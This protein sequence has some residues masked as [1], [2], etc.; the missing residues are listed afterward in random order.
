MSVKTCVYA[1]SLNEIKHIDRFLAA[2]AEADLILICDTGSTDGTVEHI[3]EMQRTKHNIVLHNIV[4][5]PW[6]FDVV[7]NTA[8]SLVPSD[9]DICLSIDIDEFL[10]PGWNAAIQTT[11]TKYP[12]V[13]RFAYDYIWSWN[14]DGTPA[15]RFNADKIHTRF[16]YRWKHPCHETLYWEGADREQRVIIDGLQLQHH[17]DNTKSRSQYLGLLK[18][19]V[20]EDANNDRMAHYYARELMFTGDHAAAITEFKR[21][22]VLPTATW[23]EE[24]SASMRY[25]A[26]CYEKLGDVEQAKIWGVKAA[27][28]CPTVREP[29]FELARISYDT[30]DWETCL[31]ASQKCLGIINDT[32]SY[33]SLAK[34]WTATPYEYAALSCFQLGMNSKAVEYGREALALDPTNV[35][36]AHNQQCF[37]HSLVRP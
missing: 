31:W 8:L 16:G 14:A 13:T 9:I 29:W 37:E 7:R 26:S 24:R 10:Q 2:S 32:K 3:R 12:T 1:I 34:C 19:A 27:L 20:E 22:L 35:R 5:R 30:Q 21:H 11:C 17:A 6:R 15:V 28:E 23:N 25:V 36:I 33:M 18:L 4:Q